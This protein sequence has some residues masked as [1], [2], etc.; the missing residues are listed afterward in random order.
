MLSE[1]A[2]VMFKFEL[3]KLL[4]EGPMINKYLDIQL[5]LELSSSL[6]RP[7]YQSE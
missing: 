4:G 2:D 6:S 1:E 5:S 7:I 3:L